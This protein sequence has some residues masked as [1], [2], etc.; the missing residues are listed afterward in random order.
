MSD[1]KA[2][3]REQARAH[4]RVADVYAE[5]IE[6]VT[7][8]FFEHVKP[9]A[10]KIVAGY[11]PKGREFDATGILERSLQEGLRCALP[12]VKEDDKV[13]EF[14]AWEKDTE[15]QKGAFGIM[16]P[17]SEEVLEPD[18]ILVPMLAF[19]RRGYRLGQG[20]GYYDATLSHWRAKKEIIA[21]GMAYA[22]Q[23]VLF[24]LPIETHDQ[25]LDYVLTP[26]GLKD[27]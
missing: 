12:V 1:Q 11:W 2:V 19:D 10:G 4:L 24:N 26:Q 17:I 13:L 3:L 21:I 27:F 16:E 7:D 22:T 15:F 6:A 23:A 5:D 9:E 18:Y 14:R 25:K 20:G 8:I